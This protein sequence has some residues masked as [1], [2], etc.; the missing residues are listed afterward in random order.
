MRYCQL[1]GLFFLAAVP[2]HNLANAL[3]PPWDEIRVKHTWNAVPSNWETL[4]HPPAGTTIDLHV[5]LMPHNENALIDA[6][7]EVS[8]PMS[9]KYGAHLSKEQV[10]QLVCPHQDTLELVKS[11]LK[12]HEVPSSSISTIQDGSWLVLTGVP[13]SQANELLGASYQLYRRTGTN[14]TTILRTT[15]YTLPAVLHGH[16][17]TV[18]PTTCFAS[19]RTLWRIPQKLT[20]NA[21][22]DLVSRG[23]VK[24]PIKPADVR[25]MYGTFGYVPAAT[26]RN[27][28]GIAAYEK[29]YPSR[30]D[31]TNFMAEYR[32]D[33][34]AATFTVVPINNGVFDL[35]VPR[36]PTTEGSLNVQWA[37][38]IA[39]P[40]PLTFYSTGGDVLVT[41][42]D[43]EPATGD[44]WLEWLKYMLTLE[45]VPQTIST[46]YAIPENIFP[47]E[48]TKTLCNMFAQLGARGVSLVFASG[49]NGVG[50]AACKANDG[51]GRVQFIPMFPA[52]CPWVTSVG[53][54]MGQYPEVA[55]ELS[56]G[57]F[58]NHFPR[59]EYQD[60]AVTTFLQKLGT[61]YNGFYNAAGRG[62]PDVAAQAL[63][64]PI[65][66]DSKTYA[67]DGTSGAT[68]IVAGIISL[69][70]DYRLSQG[71]KPLGFLNPLLYGVG[72]EGMNDIKSG[73]N[74]GCGTKGFS[75]ITGW[76]PVR[77]KRSFIP[78]LSEL[79][80]LRLCR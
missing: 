9:P 71:K 7:Y 24:K 76:D 16:V 40:T 61:K 46:S 63:E 32:T 41:P 50:D 53:G 36:L 11:W 31:L 10:D 59:E 70:N 20:V 69:L 62:I 74:P 68:P 66:E 5:A 25:W 30:A 2:F 27:A 18:I 35:S 12:H 47:L 1:S 17:R 51:T 78:S 65:F 4:G 49:N 13:V 39:Y 19:T 23:L 28:L 29:D 48:Y 38:A 73:S 67:V 60:G 15:G 57:G 22:A 14:D 42:V 37:Q 45:K 52:S 55:A 79:A 54:T 75:A 6:L 80:D 8:D 43:N 33:A 21:T 64:L 72:R 56:G 34:T 77:P 3:G 26:D 44:M 58:S